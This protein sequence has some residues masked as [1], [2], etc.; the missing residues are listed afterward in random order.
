MVLIGPLGGIREV[1]SSE[2]PT[3]LFGLQWG[4]PRRRRVIDHPQGYGIAGE[5][6][7]TTDRTLA[8]Q[9]AAELDRTDPLPCTG[10]E[11]IEITALGDR[12]P[13]LLCKWCSA[14]AWESELP[15]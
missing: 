1:P 10:H 3:S 4:R 12:E 13:R 15:D 14:T 11:W 5:D 7:R 2:L 8:E 6:F 9:V